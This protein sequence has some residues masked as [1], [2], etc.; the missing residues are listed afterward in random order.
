VREKELRLALVCFG[1]VSLAIYMHGI[2]K[3]ILKL[4]RASSALHAIVDRGARAEAS[5]F[6]KADPADPE[7]D[8]E[9]VYFDLLREVGRKVDLRVVVDIVAGASAGGINGTMLARAIGHDLPFNALRELWLE[10]ADVTGL[11]APEARAHWWSK[12]YMR[13]VLWGAMATGM[14]HRIEDKE[15]RRKLS[16][17]LR[18]RWFKAPFDGLRMAGLMYDAVLS[19][20]TPRDA[21]ASLLPSGQHLDLFVTVTDHYGYQQL[22][23]IHDPPLI[24]EREHRHILRFGYRRWPSGEIESDFELVNAPA[25]AFAARATSSFP[26]VFPAARIVEMDALVARRESAWPGRQTFIARNFDRYLRAN[27]EPAEA[28]FLDG[29]VLNN[30]PFREAIQAIA[31]RPAYRQVDRRLVYIEPDPAR[32][33]TA[34]HHKPPGFFSMLKGALSDIPRNE[35]IADELVYVNGFNERVRRQ[36]SIVEAARPEITTVV[37]SAL[38]P[39]LDGLLS[40]H[41]IRHWR[42]AM[43]ARAASDAGFAYEGYVRL[44]LASVRAFVAQ[45]IMGLRGVPQRSPFARAISEI[46]EA[47]AVDAGCVYHRDAPAAD[48]GKL[49]PWLVLLLAFDVDFRKRRLHFLIQGQNRLYRLLDHAEY[50]GVSPAVV[51][52]LK[53]DFY[54][55]LGELRRREQADFFKPSTRD[56]AHEIFATA[57]TASEARDIEAYARD[58]A[59]RQGASI[60]LLVDRLAAEIDLDASTDDIDRLLAEMTPEAWPLVARREIMVNYLGFPFWDILTFSVTSWREAGEFDE[61]LVDRISPADVRTL[62]DFGTAEGLKGTGMGHFAAF[63]SRAYRENDYLIGRLHGVDRVID[64]VCDAA[65]PGPTRDIDVLALKRRAFETILDAEEKALPHSADLIARLRRSIAAMGSGS[66]G[67][68]QS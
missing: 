44:K 7:Y 29:S 45:S 25:L 9:A 15:A 12:W 2:S 40:V 26:G 55:C 20:G 31:G 52:R 14:M 43:N 66:G 51:D 22:I 48:S 57:P 21:K 10:N 49:P 32:A 54:H 58:F 6:D 67:T 33:A 39:R 28:A 24:H 42:E 17:F 59:R 50:A 13:L 53:R 8:T 60:R 46:L 23:Q 11:L 27:I 5:F 37:A 16:F 35:P 34:F 4:V 47:W 38:G 1:G 3:E 18:S 56:M 36:K 41:E 62:R 19:M 61:V 68:G 64:I 63:F 65:G 30:K